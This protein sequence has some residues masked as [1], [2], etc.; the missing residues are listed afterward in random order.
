MPNAECRMPNAECRM[1][2]L[3]SHFRHSAFSIQH[4]A[5]SIDKHQRHPS[6]RLARP[7]ELPPLGLAREGADR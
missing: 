1:P 4:S 5:F 3:L 6:R 7:L 2:S